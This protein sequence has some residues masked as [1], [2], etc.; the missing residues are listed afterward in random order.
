MDVLADVM[1]AISLKGALYFEVHASHPWISMNPSMEQIGASMMPDADY[2]IPFHIVLLGSIFTKLDNGLHSPIPIETGDVFMLPTGEKHIITSDPEN[3]EGT[4]A[5]IE[6]YKNAAKSSRP[7]TM[8]NVGED[9]EKANLICG[10]LACDNSPFNPLLDI[11]PEMVVLKGYLEEDNLM[12]ELVNTAVVESKNNAGGKYTMVAKLSELMFLRALRHC[13][14]TLD[15]KNVQNWLTALKDKHVGKVLDL[16]HSDPTKKWTLD[17]LSSA[18]GMSSSALSERFVRFVG[19]PP[20]SYLTRWRIELACRL[21]KQG[22]KIE[23]VAHEVGYSSESAFQNSFK[24][25]MGKPAGQ[26]RKTSLNDA[27][28]NIVASADTM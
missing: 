22:K 15:S 24:K 28:K 1:R 5:D 17:S 25:I 6:F 9:G 27:E 10:Y 7:Y 26:W 19:E 14:D 13:M 12:R 18:A 16:I 20:I 23:D 11:L 2:V 3:W 21:L 8:M 4:P